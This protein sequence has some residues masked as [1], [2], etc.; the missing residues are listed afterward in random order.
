[1]LGG[2]F[3]PIKIIV[4]HVLEDDSV[5]GE[6]VLEVLGVHRFFHKQE[7]FI[8]ESIHEEH[9]PDVIGTCSTRGCFVEDGIKLAAVVGEVVD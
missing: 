5:L 7:L 4:L 8:G 1:L 6:G 9:D 2:W 3:L